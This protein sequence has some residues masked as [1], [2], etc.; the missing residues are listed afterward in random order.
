[1]K[2]FVCCYRTCTEN[3]V[4]CDII[5][6]KTILVLPFLSRHNSLESFGFFWNHTCW[7]LKF[8]IVRFRISKFWF[9]IA[10]R[11]ISI[12]R[13]LFAIMDI[14]QIL[15]KKIVHLLTH[16]IVFRNE[17]KKIMK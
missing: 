5:F 16:D 3:I 11:Y 12:I 13:R 2:A 17:I 15:Q 8:L 14:P 9:R 6:S 1:M 4:K 10:V 7:V